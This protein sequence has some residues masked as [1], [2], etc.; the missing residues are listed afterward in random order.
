MVE[1]SP[2]VVIALVAAVIAGLP[3]GAFDIFI[4]RR[5]GLW[6]TPKQLGWW[7]SQYLAVGG[8]TIALWWLSP[9]VGLAL[10]LLV[11]ALHF[12]RDYFPRNALQATGTGTIILGLPMLFHPQDVEWVFQQLFLT[13]AG[14]NGL[15]LL[16]S[17]LA[18]LGL[19]QRLY[20][21]GRN[22]RANM[23]WIAWLLIFSSGAFIFHP[24]IYFA[25]FFAFSHS[26]TH[27]RNQWR[28]LE[29]EHR[30]YAI[31]VLL[32]LTVAPVVAA[33]LIGT[34]LTFDWSQSAL[35]LVFIGLAALTMP[36][37]IL[38]ERDYGSAK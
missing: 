25:L 30:K 31:W 12:G 2:F 38:L 6:Q 35:A 14:A 15:V 13:E 11:S 20:S 36:H 5:H 16:L 22:L 27:L 34:Q 17:G 19:F 21:V 26:P 9:V 32:G 28:R 4:A 3:H 33:I 23:K 18:L 7:V 29:A 1:L 8:L 24:L 37:M 10:F